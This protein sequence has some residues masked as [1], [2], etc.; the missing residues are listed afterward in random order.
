MTPGTRLFYAHCAA[1]SRTDV[2]DTLNC[3]IRSIAYPS[4]VVST[5]AGSSCGTYADGTGTNAVLGLVIGP[6]YY[7]NGGT[8][9]IFF[10][11]NNRISAVFTGSGVTSSV[12]GGTG[13]GAANGVGTNAQFT[14]PSGV[15]VSTSGGEL[16]VADSSNKLIRSM[17]L[18]AG[19]SGTVP[20]LNVSTFAGGGSGTVG[21]PSADGDGTSATFGMPTGCTA[22]SSYL[23]VADYQFNTIRR[24]S[25]SYPFTVTTIAGNGSA[26]YANGAGTNALFNQPYSLSYDITSDAL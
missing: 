15:C 1:S 11:V 20:P 10:P 7:D 12:A 23:Y 5:L 18:T 9:V 17:P 13:P 3:R 24:V 8:P 14:N 16:Y 6:A 2:A 19:Y 25:L 21:T 22:S 26:G 4:A